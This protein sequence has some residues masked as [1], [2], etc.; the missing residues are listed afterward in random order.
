MRSHM[1]KT[2][3]ILVTI[4]S[5]CGPVYANGLNVV[6]LHKPGSPACARQVVQSA[7]SQELV[8]EGS[9]E[10]NFTVHPKAEGQESWSYKIMAPETLKDVNNSG[11]LMSIVKGASFRLVDEA[12]RP[13]PLRLRQLLIQPARV[14]QEDS[15]E[16]FQFNLITM[17]TD[18]SDAQ[19]FK[20]FKLIMEREKG[21][22]PSVVSF[23]G[24][25]DR[26]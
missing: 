9:A 8:G 16:I 6:Q 15:K 13:M 20:M 4:F 5:I 22:T 24:P 12:M 7:D 1:L 25:Y 10:M 17:S 18:K 14:H 26:I 19:V 3:L 23:D 11:W 21:K 2:N